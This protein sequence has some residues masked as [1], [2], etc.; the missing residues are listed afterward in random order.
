MK[1]ERQHVKWLYTLPNISD[2]QQQSWDMSQ[3][4]SLVLPPH[5]DILTDGNFCFHRKSQN[6]LKL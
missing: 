1:N 3:K 5:S 4:V 2:I 6:S